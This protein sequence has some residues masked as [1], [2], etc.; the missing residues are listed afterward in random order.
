M[1]KILKNS[2]N[3]IIF[4]DL[5]SLIFKYDIKEINKNIIKLF[6][7][8]KKMNKNIILPTFNLNFPETKK[9][10]LLTK[11]ITT[12]YLS[13]FLIKKF[14]FS[15][16]KRP[17]Y[18]YAINGPNEKRISNLKQSTAWGN[19]SILSYLEKMILVVWL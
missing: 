6:W 19:D 5:Q 14:K 16:S 9:T 11:D 18:N 4:S 1:D 8:L 2:K 7:Y 15:R 17:M 13:K 10:S 3:I 12:G